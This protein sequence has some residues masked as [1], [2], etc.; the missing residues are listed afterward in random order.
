MGKMVK[1][2]RELARGVSTYVTATDPAT[3]QKQ[4]NCARLIQVLPELLSHPLSEDKF[5]LPWCHHVFGDGGIHHR[6]EAVV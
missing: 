2:C 1:T 5:W 6:S 3:Q 4:A